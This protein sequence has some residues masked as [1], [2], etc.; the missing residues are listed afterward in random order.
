ME[1]L[2]LK[3]KEIVY[4]KIENNDVANDVFDCKNMR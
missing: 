3:E 1:L 4:V 2:K